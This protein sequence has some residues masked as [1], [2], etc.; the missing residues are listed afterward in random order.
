ML[1]PK[2][3]KQYPNAGINGMLVARYGQYLDDGAANYTAFVG[4]Y[5]TSTYPIDKDQFTVLHK[6]EFRLC[7]P[8]GD[9][10]G[11]GIIGISG[12]VG[13]AAVNHP[14]RHSHTW[15][16][17]LPKLHYDDGPYS[18]SNYATVVP[19][20]VSPVWAAGY[21]YADG[22]TADTAGGLLQVDMRTELWFKDD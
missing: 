7:K 4:T 13:M 1:Q 15:R 3:Q 22:T 20:N 10:D 11:A 14:I 17:K 2:I 6:R 21:Y 5:L 19:T 16:H 12:G 8:A 18:S 9:P